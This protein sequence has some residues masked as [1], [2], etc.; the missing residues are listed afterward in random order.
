[1]CLQNPS[2]FPQIRIRFL[3]STIPF[4][5]VTYTDLRPSLFLH[6]KERLVNIG[7]SFNSSDYGFFFTP[8]CPFSVF[9]TVEIVSQSIP[10]TMRAIMSSHHLVLLENFPAISFPFPTTSILHVNLCG[11]FS[12][13]SS[14][15]A[16]S[17]EFIAFC[18]KLL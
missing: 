15:F 9:L 11:H 10:L 16:Q 4:F 3:H 13:Q 17:I 1:M 5:F 14:P 6:R 2:A 18:S 12:G 8:T 7:L